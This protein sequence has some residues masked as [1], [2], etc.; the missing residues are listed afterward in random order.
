MICRAARCTIS[1]GVISPLSKS[2][3]HWLW[4]I[5]IFAIE[6]GDNSGNGWPILRKFLD[7]QQP[8]M[9]AL[10]YLLLDPGFT[11]NW[12]NQLNDITVIPQLP[13]LKACICRKSASTNQ[14]HTWYVYIGSVC[15]HM[16]RGLK[17][18]H[19]PWNCRFFCRLQ[20]LT[21]RL[22]NCIHLIFLKTSLPLHTLEAY[23][24]CTV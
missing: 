22:Q 6:H 8:Y 10:E 3:L 20:S 4:K 17:T 14:N 15:L 2:G 1:L 16:L 24:H 19:G 21:A 13:Y 18:H 9:D 11:H 23:T 12:I 7:T 5:Q